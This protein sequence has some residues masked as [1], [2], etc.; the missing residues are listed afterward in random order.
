[1][2]ARGA[3]IHALEFEKRWAVPLAPMEI[4]VKKLHSVDVHMAG[5]S[6]TKRGGRMCVHFQGLN[7]EVPR[8]PLCSDFSSGLTVVGWIEFESIELCTQAQALADELLPVIVHR[9]FNRLSPDTRHSF[10]HVPVAL[11]F[12]RQYIQD[13]LE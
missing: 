4:D 10:K 12:D 11:L 2:L 3:G 7:P 8:I 9:L 5:V 13:T 1:M 6:I